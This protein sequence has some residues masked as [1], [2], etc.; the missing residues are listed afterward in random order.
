MNALMQDIFDQWFESN[1]N[2]PITT[3]EDAHKFFSKAMDYMST[4][5]GEKNTNSEVIEIYSQY[6]V[7]SQK[8][9]I[10]MRWGENYA[11]FTPDEGRAHAYSILDCA[12]A[13]ESDEILVKWVKERLNIADDTTASAVLGDFRELRKKLRTEIVPDD[14]H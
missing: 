4:Q 14:D 8:G 11:R 5:H 2:G 7:K 1:F 12:N 10:V 9:M 6:G 3:K 13:A